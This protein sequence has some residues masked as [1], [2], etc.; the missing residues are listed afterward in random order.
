MVFLKILLVGA[1][2]AIL[3]VVARDQ[4]WAQRAGVTGACTAVAGPALQ[5]GGAWYRCKEGIVTG[6]PNLESEQC[7]SA[8]MVAAHDE[9]W[10]CLEPLVSLPGY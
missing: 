9:L 8:G 3:M 7:K 6:L 2:I 1:A 4:H 5:G 10:Q